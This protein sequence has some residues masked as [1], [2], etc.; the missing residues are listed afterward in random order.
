MDVLN[1]GGISLKGGSPAEVKAV[2]GF[3]KVSLSFISP[4]LQVPLAAAQSIKALIGP[5][6]VIT[7]GGSPY[8]CRINRF[9]TM[10]DRPRCTINSEPWGPRRSGVGHI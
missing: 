4:I 2:G 6:V 9:V 3:P 10:Q 1:R 5:A 7:S 8:C